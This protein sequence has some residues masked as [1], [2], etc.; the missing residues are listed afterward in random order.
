MNNKILNVLNLCKESFTDNEIEEVMEF[1]EVNENK[2]AL[3]TICAIFFEEGK[4]VSTLQLDAIISAGKMM[5][6]LPGKW[7]RLIVN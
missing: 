3:E 5:T 7:E 4:T 6:I 2:L 1:I